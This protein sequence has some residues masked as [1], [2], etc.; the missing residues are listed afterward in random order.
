MTAFLNELT[1]EIGEE[2]DNAVVSQEEVDVPAPEPAET[3]EPATEAEPVVEPEKKSE[4]PVGETSPWRDDYNKLKTEFDAYKGYFA[5]QQQAPVEPKQAPS[6]KS[7]RE[8]DDTDEY[9]TRME[10]MEQAAHAAFSAVKASELRAAQQVIEQLKT[11][12]P[13]IDK[14][15]QTEHLMQGVNVRI[16][17]GAYGMD[18]KE[19]ILKAYDVVTQGKRHLT[20]AEQLEMRVKELEAELTRS[21]DE[22]ANKRSERQERETRTAGMVP[23]GGGVYQDSS[24]P[25][26]PQVTG[27]FK[28]RNS[29]NAAAKAMEHALA[30]GG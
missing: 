3:P 14:V 5:Q 1:A 28:G 26:V 19:P 22:I 18:W 11:E 30:Q 23:A 21:K 20:K 17:N 8:I 12:L 15:I 27:Q 13:D 24:R 6:Q 4:E 7:L 29:Y 25:S 16:Q 10:Q 9:A 2:E